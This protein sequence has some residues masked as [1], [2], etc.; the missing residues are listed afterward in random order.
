MYVWVARAWAR[1]YTGERI[2]TIIGA[3][4]KATLETKLAQK[5]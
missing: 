5:L 3:V 4:P 1:V 2:D